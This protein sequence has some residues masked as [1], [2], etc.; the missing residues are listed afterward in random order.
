[1]FIL[2]YIFK[3][4]IWISYG[5]IVSRVYFLVPG[6]LHYV[7]IKILQNQD[8]YGLSSV[9]LFSFEKILLT[10]IVCFSEQYCLLD[11]PIKKI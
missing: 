7:I 8:V 9:H 1:M 4:N 2:R 6:E 11:L 3:R 10:Y 5:C